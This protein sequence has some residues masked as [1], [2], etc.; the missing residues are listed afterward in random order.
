MGASVG[1]D[2]GGSSGRRGGRRRRLSSAPMS[3][4]NVTPFVDVM[5]VLL[6]VFMLGAQLV[7][8]G[9]EVEL[10]ETR[11]DSLSTPQ[12]EPVAIT[13][14]AT[15]EVFLGA[16]QVDP[17]DLPALLASFDLDPAEDIIYVRGDWSAQHGRI[18]QVVGIMNDAGYARFGFVGRPE[19]RAS[20]Q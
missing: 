11:A 1:G 19:E 10:P 3:E 2:G 17:E 13:V 16:D 12:T 6:I 4:I 5:L 14:D 18:M 7:A 15:G 9:Y 8:A 20:A